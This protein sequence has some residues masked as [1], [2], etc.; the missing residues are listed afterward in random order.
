M[1]FG[2][3]SVF[4]LFP[5][6]CLEWFGLREFHPQMMM[7]DDLGQLKRCFYAIAHFSENWGYLCMSP[8]AG[9]LF[10]IVFGRNLDSHNAVVAAG[11]GGGDSDSVRR[12]GRNWNAV[13]AIH[14]SMP[15]L[16]TSSASSLK[17]APS[18]GGLTAPQCHLGRRC[19]VDTL[20]LTAGACS[21]SMLLSV[22]AGWRE[23][24]KLRR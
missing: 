22:W 24:R 8:I 6:V 12:W 3:G 4:S 11:A 14:W 16:S 21:L 9:N 10:S 2:Y 20:Y 13:A 5:N 7:I 15:S 23:R 18:S 17:R 1:G 19:Y